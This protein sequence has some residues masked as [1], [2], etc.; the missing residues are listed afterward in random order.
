MRNMLACV[1]I[2]AAHVI[3]ASEPDPD[4][5][6]AWR[7][8]IQ[9][10]PA[11]AEQRF[12][13]ELAGMPE[14]SEPTLART[15]VEIK[16]LSAQIAQGNDQDAE[17]SRLASLADQAAL[18]GD[19]RAAMQ[20]WREC[21]RRYF[22]RGDYVRAQSAAQHLLDMA[23]RLGA[24]KDE[25]QALNDLGVLAKRRGDIRMAIVHYENALGI[26]RTIAD[27][28]G[29]A[30]TLGNLALIEKNRGS[31]LQ[32]LKYQREAHRI[33]ERLAQGP[34]LANSHDSLGL[35]YLAMN[36]AEE[37]EREFRAALAVG[38]TP[39]NQDNISN[40]RNNLALA[41]MKQGRVDEAEAAAR[42]V[43]DYAVARDRRPMLTSAATTLASI[44]RRRGE[45]RD[46]GQLAKDALEIGRE[47]GDSKEII[48]PL[49]ERAEWQLAS[50]NANAA[51]VDLSEAM[52]LARRDQLRLLEYQALELQSRIQ[53]AQGDSSAAF[54]TRQDYEQMGQELLGADTLRQMAALLSEEAFAHA[55]DAQSKEVTQVR[56]GPG[57]G[58]V[59]LVF[60][61]GLVLGLLQRR[62]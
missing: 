32:A 11:A 14:S 50:S 37:A 51:A 61:S 12:A 17:L 60:L 8:E 20:A 18:L 34:L 2:C 10:D 26:R 35:I 55:S 36:D 19:L 13:S 44:L 47:V 45:L 15:I 31:L 16:L 49:L 43:Y 3:S 40:S 33:R 62:R 59:M 48:E 41:L 24:R 46:A 4:P 27:E 25:A 30:Q 29:T 23:R 39:K 6:I 54:K 52:T 28:S 22:V 57:L 7:A 56:A 53:F 21:S 1:L 42:Q 38:D 58:V 5:W 9:T